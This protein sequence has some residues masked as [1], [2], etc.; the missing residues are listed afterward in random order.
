MSDVETRHDST[1]II[2]IVHVLSNRTK[3]K[4][5]KKKKEEGAFIW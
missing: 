1:V 3:K 4:E 2:S 5:E